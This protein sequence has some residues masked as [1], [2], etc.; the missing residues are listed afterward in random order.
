MTGKKR[1]LT[2]IIF[3]VMRYKIVDVNI[4]MSHKKIV[5]LNYFKDIYSYL[6]LINSLSL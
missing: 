3:L 6:P 4:M 2:Q 5:V 1:H